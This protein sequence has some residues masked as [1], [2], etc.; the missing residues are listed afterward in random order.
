LAD[1]SVK[2]STPDKYLTIFSASAS[3]DNGLPQLN[4][5]TTRQLYDISKRNGLCMPPSAFQQLQLNT[6]ITSGSGLVSPL[7]GCGS[8]LVLDPAL[9]LGIRPGSSTSSKGRYIFQIQGIMANNTAT[10]FPACT[11]YVIGVNAAVLER[12]GSEYRNYLLT[13]PDNVLG[14]AENLNS[15]DHQTYID[16]KYSN[17]FLSGG[18]IGDWMRK[19]SNFL[20]HGARWAIKNRKKVENVYNIGKDFLESDDPAAALWDVKNRGKLEEIY[21]VGRDFLELDE[22]SRKTGSRKPMKKGGAE[23]LY[24]RDIRPKQRM[25]LFYE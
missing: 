11:L 7:Y 13:L 14:Q 12:I 8:V 16:A 21:N 18:G 5:A 23:M 24:S 15:I 20:R 22:P 19:I 1:A 3:F 17:A 6:G 2:M 10:D 25:D 4:N 9:D